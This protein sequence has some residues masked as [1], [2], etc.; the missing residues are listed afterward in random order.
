[1]FAFVWKK[2]QDNDAL[3]GA[4]VRDALVRQMDIGHQTVNGGRLSAQV[5]FGS[6][7]EIDGA[8]PCRAIREICHE[9][10]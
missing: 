8:W 6:T 9:P 10:S 4:A 2:V 7:R 1:M 3:V 5:S